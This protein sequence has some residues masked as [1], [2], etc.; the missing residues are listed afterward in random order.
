MAFKLPSIIYVLCII[1]NLLSSQAYPKVGGNYCTYVLVF[2][3][4]ST[5]GPQ[6]DMQGSFGS[7]GL[8]IKGLL[9]SSK[10]FRHIGKYQ[11]KHTEHNY[12]VL[13]ENAVL[14]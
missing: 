2:V 3:D 7:S 5:L 10:L 4:Q 12:H 9:Y 8:L 13:L 1:G 6:L 14:F 11:Y